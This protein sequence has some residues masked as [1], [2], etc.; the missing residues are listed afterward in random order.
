[1]RVLSHDLQGEK[2]HDFVENQGEILGFS[3]GMHLQ[4]NKASASGLDC[5]GVVSLFV[6]F[7]PDLL[8]RS[9][10]SLRSEAPL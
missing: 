9:A 1:M 3:A 5:H 7:L 8:A 6:G 2:I 4:I 10:H